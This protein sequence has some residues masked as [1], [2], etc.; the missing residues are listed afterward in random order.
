MTIR[1]TLL[2]RMT[3]TIADELSLNPT[4]EGVRSGLESALGQVA[5]DILA[6]LAELPRHYHYSD[7][8]RETCTVCAAAR[9]LAVIFT[10]QDGAS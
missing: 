6:V 5:R 8:S 4:A 9:R 1:E 7:S 3:N 10:D 2:T